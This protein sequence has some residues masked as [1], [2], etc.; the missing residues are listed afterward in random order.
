MKKIEDIQND[1]REAFVDNYQDLKEFMN[2][3]NTTLKKIEVVHIYNSYDEFCIDIEK[4][5]FKLLKKYNVDKV[6]S[7]IMT[8]SL[9]KIM[10]DKIMEDK[11]YKKKLEKFI[12]EEKDI[13]II[14]NK[15]KDK[16]IKTN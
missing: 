16:K 9:N 1:I 2:N 3:I 12:V 15:P 13:L 10:E 4:Q 11:D 7:K 8:E 6:T 14:K 5:L